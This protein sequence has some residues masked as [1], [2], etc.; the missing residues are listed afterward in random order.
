MRKTV[1]DSMNSGFLKVVNSVWSDHTTSLMMIRDILMY[2][3][4]VYVPTIENAS[5]SQ[6]LQKYF[7]LVML[8]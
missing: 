3:D 1:I 4:R 7:E 2:L 8:N 5:V 6:L